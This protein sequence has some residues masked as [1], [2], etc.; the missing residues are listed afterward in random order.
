MN[1]LLP[2]RAATVCVFLVF[3]TIIDLFSQINDHSDCP[4]G[5]NFELAQD[6]TYEHNGKTY[7]IPS[8][9]RMERNNRWGVERSG[10]DGI[11]YQ[12]RCGYSTRGKITDESGNVETD[13]FIITPDFFVFAW[14]QLTDNEANVCSAFFEFYELITSKG[15]FTHHTLPEV[16][17][18]YAGYDNRFAEEVPG[19]NGLLETGV[20]TI[21]PL[22]VEQGCQLTRYCPEKL[23]FVRDRFFSSDIGIVTVE[24]GTDALIAEERMEETEEKNSCYCDY[25]VRVENQVGVSEILIE[26]VFTYHWLPPEASAS[27]CAAF[28]EEYPAGASSLKTIGDNQ[29]I[30]YF[31]IE[32]LS[33]V[34]YYP[35][36]VNYPFG[37]LRG[38]DDFDF[39]PMQ[40]GRSDGFK[41]LREL[42]KERCE[43][44]VVAEILDANPQFVSGGF[45][46]PLPTNKIRELKPKDLLELSATRDGIALDHV[47]EV[48]IRFEAPG[49][50]DHIS[51]TLPEEVGQFEMVWGD[52]T[53]QIGNKHFGFALFTPPEEILSETEE[54]AS[55]GVKKFKLTYDIVLT[56]QGG[57]KNFEQEMVF[58][59]PPVVLIHGTFDNPTNCWHTPAFDGGFSM[60]E[61]LEKDGFKVFT[62]DYSATNGLGRLGEIPCSGNFIGSP[63]LGNSSCFENNK[64]VVYENP[65]G[66]KEALDYFREELNVAVTQA[67]VIGHSMGGVLARVYA[68]ENYEVN[69]VDRSQRDYIYKREENFLEGD[70]NRLITISSTHHGSD[71]AWYLAMLDEES[72]NDT[73]SFIEDTLSFALM[74]TLDNAALV[75]TFQMGT[76]WLLEGIR[77][78]AGAII[79]QIPESPALRKIGATKIP[80]HSIVSVTDRIQDAIDRI[81]DP[82]NSYYKRALFTA[83]AFYFS[84]SFFDYFLYQVADQWHKL[85]EHLKKNESRVYQGLDRMYLEMYKDD[86]EAFKNLYKDPLEKQWQSILKL[87]NMIKETLQDT[88][89]PFD[90]ADVGMADFDD[91][92]LD[93]ITGGNL[94]NIKFAV[95]IGFKLKELANFKE[96]VDRIRYLIFKNDKNDFTVRY[97]SQLGFENILNTPDEKSFKLFSNTLHGYTPR[98]PDVQDHVISLLNSGL[99][100]FNEEGFP[101]AG[102]K[103][104]VWLP[105]PGDMAEDL[106]GCGAICWS[107]YVPCHALEFARIANEENVVLL[108]R[109]VNPDATD[110]IANNRATKGMPVKGKSSN[111]GPHKG[112][113]AVDQRYSKLWQLYS[114]D[115]RDQQIQKFNEKVQDL[116]DMSPELV[117]RAHLNDLKFTCDG[118]EAEYEMFVVK[119]QFRS[120]A[121]MEI[122]LLKKGTSEIYSWDPQG[123]ID[124]PRV[125]CTT[126]CDLQALDT[127]FVQANPDPELADANGDPPLYTADYDL[128]AIGFFD[129]RLFQN[130]NS[131]YEPP[132]FDPNDWDCERGLISQDQSELVSK[133]N[134]GIKDNTGYT[135]GNVVHHGPENH[136]IKI[137]LPN[138]DCDPGEVKSIEIPGSPYVDYPVTA[139]EPH[140]D[141]RFGATGIVRSIPMGP[142]GYRDIHLKNYFHRMRIRGYDLYSNTT[143]PGWQ[144]EHYRPY[145]YEEG[146]D[147][148]DAPELPQSVAQ[149]PRPMGEA[150]KCKCQPPN[151]NMQLDEISTNTP[152]STFTVAPNP[153]KDNLTLF[154]SAISDQ[155][156][157]IILTDLVGNNLLHSRLQLAAGPS[158]AELDLPELPGGI[159]YIT[160]RSQSGIQSKII[161]IQ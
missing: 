33:L 93:Y 11:F 131:T 23:T 9:S 2:S 37:N 141:R 45:L 64:Q 118:T 111:W 134:Q 81:E 137:T 30:D 109:P 27:V 121:E 90:L 103:L 36:S 61:R 53:H 136:F 123:S 71:M 67:D 24:K 7:F 143:A 38:N 76:I 92:L 77:P 26:G 60:V 147:P 91:D 54:D 43:G 40:M 96:F 72:A 124:C 6:L 97:D 128:L 110:L 48:L 106:T 15:D 158:T 82:N 130:P 18:V 99:E 104:P 142:P 73:L 63:I 69:P 16:K 74:K 42:A 133:I 34:G 50:K 47:S 107:G 135:A 57:A 125:L 159:Y 112:L 51:F 139:F 146:F 35:V 119:E 62:V 49:K 10:E 161:S 28:N 151:A 152:V 160:V 25:K 12:C 126:N 116:L 46:N 150:C 5:D 1:T 88:L 120:E 155:P 154:F 65:G 113:L 101:P 59:P 52:T 144:W 145:S 86:R 17:M 122:R 153:A 29:F 66:I 39:L 114:G 140:P 3:N 75:S 94:E 148:R 70:I 14:N 108:A 87:N 102:R 44:T 58:Y 115:K 79:D 85:P 129:N 138:F 22:A 127:F 32:D 19:L 31:G 83:V 20:S 8:G 68:S 56:D 132:M 95:E 105:D 41:Y 21:L 80:A 89:F 157:D 149:I 13:A 98:Y 4:C 84:Q 55:G 156:V 117:A 78:D 100:R